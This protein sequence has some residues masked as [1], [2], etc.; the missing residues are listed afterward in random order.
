MPNVVERYSFLCDTTAIKTIP[1]ETVGWYFEKMHM[2]NA[3]SSPTVLHLKYLRMVPHKA[4]WELVPGIRLE[5][6]TMRRV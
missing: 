2:A 3:A 5:L 4:V 1:L 6:D